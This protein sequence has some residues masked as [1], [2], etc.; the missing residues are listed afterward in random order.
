[1]QSCVCLHLAPARDSFSKQSSTVL[2]NLF[3]TGINLNGFKISHSVL[4]YSP[5]DV[6]H[7]IPP[8]VVLLITWIDA[9]SNVNFFRPG[10]R[11]MKVNQWTR[12]VWKKILKLR[13]NDVINVAR[14]PW[15]ELGRIVPA[16]SYVAVQCFQNCSIKYF[17]WQKS[18]WNKFWIFGHFEHQIIKSL[19]H[20]L[21]AVLKNIGFFWNHWQT[22]LPQ[23]FLIAG[24]SLSLLKR[25]SEKVSGCFYTWQK[26]APF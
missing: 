24:N 5:M 13:R 17:F 8:R 20:T 12:Y 6:S 26:F 11:L 10:G 4:D 22:I 2:I 25:R 18:E 1:M 7:L 21:G 3:T 14:H 16:V 15:C 9:A 23:F 19:V